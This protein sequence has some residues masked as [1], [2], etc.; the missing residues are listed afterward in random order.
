[1]ANSLPLLIFLY[2]KDV[3]TEGNENRQ[4]LQSVKGIQDIKTAGELNIIQTEESMLL[5]NV[6]RE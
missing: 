2:A 4:N 5:K 6:Y 1:M 3:C